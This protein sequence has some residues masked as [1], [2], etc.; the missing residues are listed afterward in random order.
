MQ[1]LT[2][3]VLIVDSAEKN[4]DLRHA[5]DFST[6][7]PIVGMIRGR[8][9]WLVVPQME[10]GRASRCA[11]TKVVTPDMLK[12][13]RRHRRRISGW[14]LGLLRAVGVRRV[15]VGA[16]F[17]LGVARRLEAA[18]VRIRVATQP[19]FPA[20]AVKTPAEIAKIRAV[21]SAAVAAMQE[22][23][24]MIAASRVDARGFLRTGR[25]YLTSERVRACIT[26]ALLDRQ[27]MGREIIVAGG[28]QGAD[29]HSKGEGPLRAHEA[30]VIDIFPKHMD[31]GYWGDITR[32][33]IKG[34]PGARLRGMY[35][36]VYAA[37]REALRRVR[38]GASLPSI[39][40]AV[41]REFERRGY[42]TDLMDGKP[43]GFIHGTG[44]GV[45]LDI[46]ESPSIGVAP[47]RLRRGNVITIE[48][49]LY[50]PDLGGVR[51]EDT[52]VVTASGFK[53]LAT[54]GKRFEA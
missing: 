25:D 43:C 46:H 26:R 15:T 2:M 52:V 36:A 20:R 17:P 28:V 1:K 47:G 37:Q 42:P 33:V 51:I 4:A 35:Q 18:G 31:H 41:I 39:H 40:R 23:V 24:R 13:P 30:I 12:I 32:T 11:D 16:D 53:Y 45:G 8:E 6:P 22:A 9:R 34:T 48:P 14:A 19:L 29:P 5:F 50:Y 38:A 44:H 7:D 3:P 49:G 54:C 21:Q 10:F 27:C